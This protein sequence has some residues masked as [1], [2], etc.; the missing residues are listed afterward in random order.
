MDLQSAP[1]LHE[2]VRS[3]L[4]QRRP[5]VA[6]ASSPFAGSLPWPVN[7]ETAAELEEAVRKEGATPA[8]VVVRKGR[9]TL[10]IGHAELRELLQV[11]DLHR[12]SR[13]D[14][15]A[16]VLKGRDATVTVAAAMLLSQ[17]AGIRVL[18]T[19]A[20][21]GAQG[22][23]LNAWDVS[24]DLVEFSLTPVAVVC[25]GARGILDLTA[26]LEI[27]ESY[28]VPVVGY[29]TAV[30]PALYIPISDMPVSV[31]VDSPDEA[32]TL[33]RIHWAMGGS[34]LVVAQ[35]VP[36]DVALHPDDFKGGLLDLER[37]ASA[38]DVGGRSQPRQMAERLARL[39]RGKTV[40]AYRALMVNNARLAARM[41]ISLL[42]QE[43]QVRP[44]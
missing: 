11:P 26:T 4:E 39:T 40:R 13:R 27:L 8:M 24:A 5:V 2:E 32:A 14:L 7:A 19:G 23:P 37:V 21:G 1:A 12:A 10:G 41:A 17:Q 35:P 42:A 31:R 38:R 9:P 28:R 6:V 18:S 36:A 29:R 34:G 43:A 33:A 20:I 30:F 44:A 22:S 16:C 3:A 15:P 25:S